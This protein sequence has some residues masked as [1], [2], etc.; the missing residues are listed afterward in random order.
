MKL[1]LLA[2]ALIAAAQTPNL[3][4]RISPDSAGQGAPQAFTL[5]SCQ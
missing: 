3:E 5:N 1:A 4:L 2:V